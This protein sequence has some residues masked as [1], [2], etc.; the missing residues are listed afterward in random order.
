MSN[1]VRTTKAYWLSVDGRSRIH[2]SNPLRGATVRPVAIR[3]HNQT[4]ASEIAALGLILASLQILDGLLTGI[5]VFHFDAGLGMEANAML[6]ELMS[7]LGVIPALVLVKT[8]AVGIVS[9]LCLYAYSVAWLKPALKG[10][11]ALYAVFAVL[12][13]SIILATEFLA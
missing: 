4:A 10:V 3:S 7:L 11:I 5:G 13:W 12:P 2:N 9:G 6:R 8:V 1:A